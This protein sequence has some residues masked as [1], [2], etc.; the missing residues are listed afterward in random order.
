MGKNRPF[1][2]YH[3]RKGDIPKTTT[4]KNQGVAQIY[5]LVFYLTLN[6]FKDSIKGSS[7]FHTTIE[8]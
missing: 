2:L 7:E 4:Y 1:I 3:M 5:T 6:S 8:F